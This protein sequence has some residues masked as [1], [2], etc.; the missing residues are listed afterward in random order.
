MSQG[1]NK[2]I[3]IGNLGAEPDGRT[4]PNGD[5][6]TNIS[7]ATSEKWKDKES[8]ELHEKTEWHRVVFFRRLADVAY[9][10]L[11]KGSKVYIEGKLQTRKWTDNDGTD[12]YMTEVVAREMQMLDSRSRDSSKPRQQEVG[13]RQDPQVS[14]PDEDIPF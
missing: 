11:R 12:R 14:D 7:V 5:S 4:L 13:S 3:L 8:G 2:V 10:Y 1:I 6:V 9:Q